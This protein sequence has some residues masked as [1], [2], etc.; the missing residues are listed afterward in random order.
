MSQKIPVAALLLVLVAG[1]VAS[2]LS[3]TAAQRTSGST[4]TGSTAIES[5]LAEQRSSRA[6]QVLTASDTL[7]VVS[8][9]EHGDLLERAFAAM[10]GSMVGDATPRVVQADDVS[11]A[12]LARHPL[13]LIGS[14]GTNP[15]VAEALDRYPI[16][17]GDLTMRLFDETAR[18]GR[19]MS[20]FS[21][22][23]PYANL[24]LRGVNPYNPDLGMILFT[25]AGDRTLERYRFNLDFADDYLLRLRDIKIRW[26]QFSREPGQ[27]LVPDP[28]AERNLAVAGTPN[29]YEK[30]K[31]LMTFTREDTLGNERPDNLY[32]IGYPRGLP[33]SDRIV[34]AF[35]RRAQALREAIPRISRNRAEPRL[36]M[37]IYADRQSKAETTGDFSYT[38]SSAI[39]EQVH[40]LFDA[41]FQPRDIT[42][43]LDIARA[44]LF[45]GVQVLAVK[46]GLAPAISDYYRGQRIGR[47]TSR[48][49]FAEQLPSLAKLLAND[50]F[51]RLSPLVSMPAAASFCQFVMTNWA[52]PGTDDGRG[53]ATLMSIGHMADDP[54]AQARVIL[55]T[56]IEELDL[57]WRQ[58]IQE[59]YGKRN[60]DERQSPRDVAVWSEDNG[61]PSSRQ[62]GIELAHS[63]RLETGVGSRV[64]AD[65]MRRLTDETG[66]RWVSLGPTFQLEAPNSPDIEGF[67]ERPGTFANGTPD[68]ALVEFLTRADQA[69]LH[70]TLAPRLIVPDGAA[71]DMGESH[72]DWERFFDGY[73]SLLVHH[74][75]L[76]HEHGVDMLVIGR[77]VGAK[78]VRRLANW[79]RI[80]ADVRRVY[81]GPLTFAAG[82][83]D[84]MENIH[85][86]GALDA[87]GVD[88]TIP[89]VSPGEDPEAV[90]GAGTRELSVRCQR[91]ARRNHKPVIVT[92]VRHAD[93]ASDRE[94]ALA[95]ATYSTAMSRHAWFGGAYWGRWYTDPAL[96][97]RPVFGT[98]TP[99]RQTTAALARAFEDFR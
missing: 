32:S 69:G 65:T 81:E 75:I 12:E 42:A 38:H 52:T 88:I 60:A 55:E 48:L 4:A 11:P 61:T 89:A 97:S 73:R 5:A 57:Q 77:G 50:E 59:T 62:A 58:W 40:T 34:R 92:G 78:A 90:Y 17:L 79:R 99:G 35:R 23:A 7:V 26:G 47:R 9:G 15:W 31:R 46:R 6:D 16:F 93:P 29:D 53:L 45:P 10:F 20:R 96:N 2:Q 51:V 94:Q 22:S 71:V 72:N 19:F 64:M 85:F 27:S 36:R 83:V 66:A 43:E 21:D 82:S 1:L 39:G 30:N 25:A 33:N 76:A 56:T 13:V 49:L 41:N 37:Y 8:G 95:V 63:Y 70:V 80:I 74:A 67:P 54:A 24:A 68:G 3:S 14:P 44:N 28:A 86:W 91:A 18:F 98:T 87:I 84:E